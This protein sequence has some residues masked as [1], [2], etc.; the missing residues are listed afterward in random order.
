MRTGLLHHT[1]F[2]VTI[3]WQPSDFLMSPNDGWSFAV[4]LLSLLPSFG[5]VTPFFPQI[6]SDHYA[7][8]LPPERKTNFGGCSGQVCPQCVCTVELLHNPFAVEPFHKHFC[9][10]RSP[11]PPGDSL[12]LPENS[13]NFQS[14]IPLLNLRVGLRQQCFAQSPRER[15]QA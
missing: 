13:S 8:P 11:I 2:R 3:V 15:D 9:R 14:C 1:L 6:F 10:S 5:G 4:L 7:S 12:L